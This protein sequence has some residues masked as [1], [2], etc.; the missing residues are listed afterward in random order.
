MIMMIVMMMM[1]T[2]DQTESYEDDDDESYDEDQN[3]SYDGKDLVDND[4]W[5]REDELGVREPPRVRSSH[6]IC[7]FFH[8]YL[9]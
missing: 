3:E 2:D 4:R 1:M 8:L 6:C 7:Y 5:R 9:Y